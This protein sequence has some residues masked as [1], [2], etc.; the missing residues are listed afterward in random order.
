MKQWWNFFWKSIIYTKPWKV[1]MPFYYTDA[2]TNMSQIFPWFKEKN[3]P[4]SDIRKINSSL[5]FALIYDSSSLALILLHL[6]NKWHLMKQSAVLIQDVKRK[7]HTVST[8]HRKSWHIAVKASIIFAKTNKEKIM[9]SIY[10]LLCSVNASKTYLFINQ[11]IFTHSHKE[12][13]LYSTLQVGK[14]R[15]KMK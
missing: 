7:A 1:Q 4:I 5:I 2:S 12:G 10:A 13:D 14:I 3:M 11:E 9:Y 15:N 6:L 8:W